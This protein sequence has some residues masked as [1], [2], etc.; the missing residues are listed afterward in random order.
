MWCRTKEWILE[1]VN[2]PNVPNAL[3]SEWVECRGVECSWVECWMR[4]RRFEIGGL[5]TIETKGFRAVCRSRVV[6]WNVLRMIQRR[7]FEKEFL[8]TILL[9]IVDRY[10]YLFRRPD[11][12]PN[13]V[14]MRLIARNI[15]FHRC[16]T[17]YAHSFRL[18]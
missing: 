9:R 18:K 6:L 10:T 1:L 3:M 16:E 17:S 12:A 4:A 5:Y 14:A 2:E 15:G 7:T 13:A 8:T 11:V